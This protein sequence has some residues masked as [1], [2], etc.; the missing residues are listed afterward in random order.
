MLLRALRPVLQR[1]NAASQPR[2]WGASNEVHGEAFCV[3]RNA[4]PRQP[5]RA[6]FQLTTHR[7]GFGSQAGLRDGHNGL[8]G[9][10]EIRRGLV[11]RVPNNQVALT[12][13]GRSD[14]HGEQH[15]QLRRKTKEEIVMTQ[16]VFVWP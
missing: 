13:R 7:R 16:P 8:V 4:K 14:H 6:P 1:R 9:G 12:R 10:E 11:E 2:L 15:E 3:E 5:R